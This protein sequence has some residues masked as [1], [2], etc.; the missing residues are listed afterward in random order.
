M[1]SNQLYDKTIAVISLFRDNIA[2]VNRVFVER[3][4]WTLPHSEVVHI[5]IEGD[6]ADGT[7]EQLLKVNHFQTVIKKHDSGKPR[8]GSIIVQERLDIL[9][10][11]WNIGLDIADDLRAKNVIIL[12][13]DIITPPTVIN[14]LLKH[15]KDTIAPMLMW[16][17]NHKHFRDTWAYHQG[18]NDFAPHYP[19]HK[20]YKKD[21]LFEV[22]GVGVPLI[23]AKVI[24]SGVRCDKNEVRGLC[25]QIKSRGFKIHVDPRSIVF[26]PV[27][28]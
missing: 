1:Q 12:D 23:Q 8:Y 6:S 14:D 9:S 19:Y 2:D 16:E 11:L 22:D 25:R 27:I 21:R 20:M 18:G 17:N 26:H 10:H 5:C 7:Y 4:Q 3:A 15:N 24:K 13:S 28:K